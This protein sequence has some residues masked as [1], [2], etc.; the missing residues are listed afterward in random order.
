MNVCSKSM[1]D[2][3]RLQLDRNLHGSLKDWL[4]ELWI[5][6]GKALCY[7]LKYTLHVLGC[8]K[9]FELCW[10]L[11]FVNYGDNDLNISK[12]DDDKS[13]SKCKKSQV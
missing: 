6:E 13:D 10:S 2:G 4:P 7:S 5:S 1:A 8:Y 9:G 3:S 12:Y 11:Y